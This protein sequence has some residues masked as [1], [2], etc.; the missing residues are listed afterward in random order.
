M[1]ASEKRIIRFLGGE[2]KCFII[3]VYQRPYSWKKDH[4]IQLMKDLKDVC[5]NGYSSHFFGSIVYVS[6]NNG[7]CEE[8]TIIDGQQRITTV[9]LLLLA[10]R[11]YIK[12]NDGVVSGLNPDKI[13]SYLTDEYADDEKKL[14]LKLVQG[15]DD[16][17][18]KLIQRKAPIA[19]NCITAN[20]EYFYTEIE[21][22]SSD[23]IEAL[24]NAITKLDIVC[25]SLETDRGDDPQLIFES[26]N[27]TG[28]EL[29]PSDKIRNYVLMGMSA[30]DQDKFYKGYWEPL[31]DAVDRKDITKFFRYYLDV[32]L[33]R[34]VAE[35]KLYTD[36]KLY[37]ETCGLDMDELLS[38]ILRYA[39]YF[40]I[41]VNPRRTKAPYSET[42]IRINKLEVNTSIPLIL[43]IFNAE[44]AGVISTED[45]TKAIEIIENYI[46]RREVCGL[47]TNQLNKIFVSL[48]AEIERDM[49]DDNVGYYD[50]FK[51]EI[52]KKSGKARFPN[53]HDFLDRFITYELYNAKSS[54]KKYILERLE[55]CETKE[56]VA[57]EEQI[58]DGTLTIEHIMPQTLSA[59]WKAALGDTWELVHSKYLDT[60]GNLTLTA[61]NSDYSNMVFEKKKS[62][63]QKGFSYSK[64]SLNSYV[65]ECDKWGEEEILERANRLY[66]LAEKI[67]WI[68]QTEYVESGNTE[69]VDWD[70]EY[71]YTNKTIDHISVMGMMIKVSNNVDAYRKI[72]EALYELDPTVYHTGSFPWFKTSKKGLKSPYQIGKEAYIETN[73]GN[74]Q[75]MEYIKA[76]AGALGLSSE[77]IRYSVTTEGG[78]FKLDDASTYGN[79]SVGK[80]AFEMFKYILENDLITD[81]EVESFKTKEYT[82]KIFNKTDYPILA[83]NRMDN[84]GN[85]KYIRYRAESVTY[86]GEQVFVTTQWFEDNRKDVITWYQNHLSGKI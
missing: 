41:I 47:E 66:K 9:S 49:E 65:K 13:S 86:N 60:P 62:L 68:P 28:Q 70:E 29:E 53:N 83:D 64:L 15:D 54:V 71:D 8:H 72:H 84:K 30:K 32:K 20:Y 58:A 4:C 48:G 39:E 3:P 69:W 74:Q 18:N 12:S 56:K 50:A 78:A 43:D 40:K 82:K 36:F 7:A 14:K 26:M 6:Q 85:S 80:M 76:V 2:D 45:A 44:D 38:D 77:D 16:A 35:K 27:S 19:D 75:K 5:D 42:L 23:E 52:L 34:N 11:N 37:R 63:S 46:V 1:Q 81:E 10:I 31:E 33:R 79:V 67:W 55:N 61:Y 25:I 59:D 73:R 24:Y 21:K 57:V 22:M 51:R 17:Y